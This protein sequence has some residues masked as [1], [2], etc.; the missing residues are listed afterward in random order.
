MEGNK[1]SVNSNG[2]SHS[3]SSVNSGSSP[4]QK[5]P[6]QNF[7]SISENQNYIIGNQENQEEQYEI[8]DDI[9]I[10]GGNEEIPNNNNEFINRESSKF[11]DKTENN[12]SKIFDSVK[13]N[14]SQKKRIEEII[15]YLKVQKQPFDENDLS[16][17]F[18]RLDIDGDNRISSD[19]IKKFLNSLRTPVNDFY[20]EKIIS[21]FDSNR[22][23]DIEKREFLNKMNKQSGKVNR[24]DLT[25]LLEIFK[26]FDANHDNKICEQDLQNIMKAL[27]ENFDEE[28]CKE[29]IR[30]LGDENGYINFNKFFDLVKEE[31][32]KDI[33]N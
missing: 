2:S 14:S 17:I 24:G 26:L 30:F 3:I 4:P 16:R 32:K 22:D 8:P 5:S 6:N 9:V 12:T 13:Q 29:M 23:G 11:F 31:G 21:E 27:G 28:T 10:E 18:D 19:E 33:Y 1:A 20:I 25:E 7:H 15:S